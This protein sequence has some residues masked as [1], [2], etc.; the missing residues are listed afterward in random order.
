[1]GRVMSSL[2]PSAEGTVLVT[3]AQCLEE[4]DV[5]IRSA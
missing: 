5:D 3:Q 2:L 4:G 1:M